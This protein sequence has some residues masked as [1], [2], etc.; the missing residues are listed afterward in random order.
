MDHKK[1]WLGLKL[2]C[3]YSNKL[4][5]SLYNYFG[6]VEE[7]WKADLNNFERDFIKIKGFSP[8]LVEKLIARKKNIDLDKEFEK[9]LSLGI[10]LIT[11]QSRSYPP[12]LLEIFNS[13]PLLFVRGELI[14]KQNR[15]IAI[16][17]SRRASSYGKL[18]AEELAC[19]LSERG[20]TVVS[21]LARGIDSAV[22]KGAL[23]K[24]GGTIAVLG[25]GLDTVYPPENR[26]LFN[27][28]SEKG[29]VVSE[30]PLGT[31]PA[32]QNFP[33]RNRIISGLADGVVV[34]EA[35]EKSGALITADFALDQGR[36]VFAVPGSV[37]NRQSKGSHKLIKAGACLI[38]SADDILDELGFK[39]EK[40]E[41]KKNDKPDFSLEEQMILEIL[42]D[43]S[44]QIETIVDESR[45][46]AAKVASTLT[47]LEIRGFLK[48]DT[49]KNYIR[50]RY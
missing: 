50:T 38:E 10:E 32:Q 4:F 36:E 33:L 24:E 20:I 34:V 21:G 14:K 39:T 30:F 13:P 5:M 42:K 44:K 41:D 43:E 35:S 3:G 11:I 19:D 8:V 25:C 28:I 27:D 29:S 40:P 48:Q 45:F 7:A 18:V 2:I 31:I 22:H 12:L 6:S 16:V 15:S 49:G 17:G 9:V 26:K 23:E 47:L 46:S 1:Y 37:K